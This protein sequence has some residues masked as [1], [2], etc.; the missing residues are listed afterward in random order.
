LSG[1]SLVYDPDINYGFVAYVLN[2]TEISVYCFSAG[3][4]ITNNEAVA[5]STIY[6]CS[7]Q[8]SIN[9]TIFLA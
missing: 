3:V 8:V 2:G 6:S 7:T 4:K 5:P 9:H 1:V